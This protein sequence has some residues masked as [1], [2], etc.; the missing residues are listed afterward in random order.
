MCI[1]FI[2]LSYPYL[3]TYMFISL[4]PHLFLFSI[5]IYTKHPR[6]SVQPQQFCSKQ[7]PFS[8]FS[9][10]FKPEF[11]QLQPPTTESWG[12]LS[13]WV[14]Q[15]SSALPKTPLLDLGGEQGTFLLWLWGFVQHK[16]PANCYVTWNVLWLQP[17]CPLPHRCCP[18]M[19]PTCLPLELKAPD[20]S[21][22]HFI[23][24]PQKAKQ[25]W[26]DQRSQAGFNRQ[27]WSCRLG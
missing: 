6:V 13:P 2:S 1:Y 22:M 25:R 8:L 24:H 27:P 14:P 9:Y 15:G 10:H 18:L 19:I 16:P 21:Q 11:V 5:H 3:Y 23:T 26:E 7:G 4:H 12:A 20:G 17:V